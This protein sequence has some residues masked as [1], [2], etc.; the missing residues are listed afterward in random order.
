MGP[1]HLSI[2]LIQSERAWAQAMHL[3]SEVSQE[4]P[5][6]RQ[7]MIRRLMRAVQA[8]KQLNAICAIV[9]DEATQLQAQAYSLGCFGQLSLE[10]DDWATALKCFSTAESIYKQLGQ[11]SDLELRSLCDDR[12]AE[13]ALFVTFCASR[14]KRLDP[15]AASLLSMQGQAAAATSSILQA[16][17]QAVMDASLKSQTTVMRTVEWQGKHLEVRSEKLR[18]LLLESLSINNNIRDILSGKVDS[19][20]TSTSSTSSSSSSSSGSGSSASSSTSTSNVD[21]DDDVD[22]DD[23]DDDDDD[24]GKLPAGD[25][26]AASGAAEGSTSASGAAVAASSKKAAAAEAKARRT[27]F[28]QSLNAQFNRLMA[29]YDD[30]TLAI[31]DD[32]RERQSAKVRSAAIE[33]ELH[34]LGGLL[35]YVAFLRL[36]TSLQLNARTA[37]SLRQRFERQEA[38]QSAKGAMAQSRRAKKQL[39]ALKPQALV[40]VFERLLQNVSDLA[41][42]AEASAT[43]TAT[44]STSAADDAAARSTAATA[45]AS[46]KALI[47]ARRLGI[48][49]F[50]TYYLAKTHADLGN[51]AAHFALLTRTIERCKEATQAIEQQMK[52]LAGAKL[53]DETF[54]RAGTFIVHYRGVRICDDA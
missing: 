23:D 14:L 13:L 6:K 38:L 48:E 54:L 5:R 33:A 9:A 52:G 2:P 50:R 43:I 51:A 53:T 31:K 17:L 4:Q 1:E 28:T 35:S 30:A 8:S 18:L 36:Q 29:I 16:K 12:A 15:S 10:R 3:Q 46:T 39:T 42:S 22:D 27:A 20:A 40:T 7:H 34:T 24:E 41:Q 37:E 26:S 47:A 45:L 21:G 25:A 32:V 44:P 19:S 11:V 49:A